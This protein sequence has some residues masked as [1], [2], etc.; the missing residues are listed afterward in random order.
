M[1]DRA[2]AYVRR[3]LERTLTDTCQIERED[4]TT[5]SMG[6]P[7]HGWVIVQEDVP[8]RVIRVAGSWSGR[9][10]VVSDRESMVEEFRL[11]LP[12]GTEIGL[13]YRVV[14]SGGQAYQVVSIVDQWTNAA[15]V[16]VVMV[17]ERAS[18]G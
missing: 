2:L 3:Q 18:D 4:D 13:D 9:T 5:G 11:I 15:D 14:L 17:R 6:E 1:F 16:Q 10:E 7:H 12:F 8:C